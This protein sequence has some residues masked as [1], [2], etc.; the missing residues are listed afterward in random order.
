MS[1]LAELLA[2]VK[3]TPGGEK[4]VPPGLREIVSSDKKR[5]KNKSTF[6]MLSA[7]FAFSI[8]AGL[9]TVNYVLNQP[10][11]KLSLLKLPMRTPPVSTP[12]EGSVSAAASPHY[13]SAVAVPAVKVAAAI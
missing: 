2:K 3:S 4:D 1:L 11:P 9:A 6:F 8:V 7:L 10:N 5:T 13:S 12:K